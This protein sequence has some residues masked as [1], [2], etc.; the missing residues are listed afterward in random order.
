M[1]T[2][3]ELTKAPAPVFGLLKQA[4][5][6]FKARLPKGMAPEKFVAA[7]SS[8]IQKTPDLLL[9][10]PHSVILAAYEAADLGISLSPALQ[11][12][13]LIPYAKVCQFQL[14]YRGMIQ[15]A[16][17]TKLI[18]NFFAEVVYTKDQFDRQL[19]PKRN[20]FHA[21]SKDGDRTKEHAIGSYA[22]VQ[23]KSDEDGRPGYLE[24]EYLTRDQIEK[25]RNHSK[26]PNSMMWNTFWEEA[27]RKTP[28]RVLWKRVPI[29]NDD[30]AK[31]AEAIDKDAAIDLDISETVA[32][33]EEKP[34][35][36]AQRKAELPEGE[37]DKNPEKKEPP[38]KAAE[39]K[40]PQR[41]PGDDQEEDK[42]P[43]KEKTT[44]AG[45]KVATDK[46]IKEFLTDCMM[47]LAVSQADLKKFI[48]ENYQMDWPL[49]GVSKRSLDTIYSDLSAARK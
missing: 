18:E 49:T 19:A 47:K 3:T 33:P 24:F 6:N 29:V 31:I 46:E 26:Q 44:P 36:T 7:V 15:L 5:G 30:I 25:H 34:I 41:E 42:N 28:I 17:R 22:L 32:T 8:A 4:M 11:L 37:P 2:G 48:K 9:C 39:T 38:K 40:A 35:K 21:P 12:G 1:A 43:P 13:Y 27:W 45:E 20:L 23:F 14:G 10:D 16:Y